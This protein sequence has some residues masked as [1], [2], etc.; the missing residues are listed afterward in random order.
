MRGATELL[1]YE[2]ILWVILVFLGADNKVRYIYMSYKE[3][4]E[5]TLLQQCS[6][7]FFAI[8]NISRVVRCFQRR[9]KPCIT[10]HKHNENPTTYIRIIP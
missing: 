10:A 3:A 1:A 5:H 9:K 2:E 7:F 6:R 8:Y 4:E